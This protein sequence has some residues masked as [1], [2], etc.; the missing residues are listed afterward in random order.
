MNYLKKIFVLKS[1]YL[2][3]DWFSV[4]KNYIVLHVYLFLQLNGDPRF[5]STKCS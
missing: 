4:E 1:F 3:V 2:H 5:D